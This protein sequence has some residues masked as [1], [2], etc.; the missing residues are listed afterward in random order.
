M[1][2]A[3]GARHGFLSQTLIIL[4]LRSHSSSICTLGRVSSFRRFRCL[5]GRLPTLAQLTI[6]AA[7]S[8][9]MTAVE[10]VPLSVSQPSLIK[11]EDRKRSMPYDSSDAPPHKKQATATNGASKHID[12]DMPWKD[13]LEVSSTS[14]RPFAALTNSLQRYQKDAIYRQMREY[15]R[16]RETLSGQLDDLR[17]KTQHHDDHIRAIDAWFKQLLAEVKTSIPGDDDTDMDI[18]SLPSSLMFP[19]QPQLAEHISSRTHEIQAI[20]SRLFSRSK[21]FTPEVVELQRRINDLLASE[22]AHTAEVHK[23]RSDSEDLESRLETAIERY[24]VAE[25]RYERAKSRAVA[26]LEKQA[27][28]GPAKSGDES[29]QVKK[30]EV[31]NGASETSEDYSELEKE[32]KK[33]LA[34]SE[35][36]REQLEKLRD[37]ISKMTAQ[38]TEANAKSATL[39]DDD[40]AK[41]ELFKQLKNQYEDTIKKLNDLEAKVAQVKEENRKL[42]QE[43]TSYQ[44]KLDDET[45]SAIAEKDNQL[46]LVEKDLV[47]IRAERDTLLADLSIQKAASD[48]E[49]EASSKLKELNVALEGRIKSLESEVE[50]LSADSSMAV[51]DAQL[52]A[53]G[54]QELRAKYQTLQKQ[55]SMLSS[56][57]SAMSQAFNSTVKSSKEKIGQLSALEEKVVRLSGEKQKADHKYFAAMRFKEARDMEI[58]TLK[59]QNS[60]SSEV[61]AQLKETEVASRNLVSNLEKQMAELKEGLTAKTSECR[62]VQLDKSNHELE[63]ARLN[64]QIMELKQQMTAKDGEMSKKAA[65]HD[66]TAIEKAEIETTLGHTRKDLEKWK[67]NSGSSVVYEDL[68]LMLYCHCKK[69]MKNAIIKTCGHAMC[70]DCI[71]ERV[72]S[73]S[74]K[75]PRCSKSFGSN[76]Y[77]TITL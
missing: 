72:Q 25:K 3:P 42:T 39:T 37:E 55:H 44:N 56:E 41:T 43:R 33:V 71:N 7:Y 22:Q 19:N 59:M 54:L 15:K 12:A 65:A 47:R 57:L 63:L 61:L 74:R 5:Q 29:A 69:N 17:K 31:T 76:D 58:K 24:V 68:R 35:T 53:L 27:T 48:Q 46:G 50:R 4:L 52:D 64:K 34:V 11:M 2:S 38:C 73:R 75:C 1:K 70:F 45:R 14:F 40:Y 49:L 66:K 20:I 23:L 30:E 18:M 77:M 16:E 13:D 10:K 32:H 36:Q 8:E 26:E 6:F 9:L 21:A 28:L 51:D 60:K 62:H 67:S